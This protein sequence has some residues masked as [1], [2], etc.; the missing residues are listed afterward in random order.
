MSAPPT[1]R[2]QAGGKG[3][4]SHS[5]PVLCPE[6]YGGDSTGHAHIPDNRS[7]G[8]KSTADQFGPQQTRHQPQ[9]NSDPGQG[10]PAVNDHVQMRRTD[11]PES[12][13]SF[14][15]QPIGHV[16]LDRG[17]QTGQRP[18]Q[19]PDHGR[20][21]AQKHRSGTRAILLDSLLEI[22]RSHAS[23]RRRQWRR[24]APRPAVELDPY[25]SPPDLRSVFSSSGENMTREPSSAVPNN[26]RVIE[27]MKTNRPASDR[28]NDAISNITLVFM[29]NTP[30]WN[31][32][33]SYLSHRTVGLAS[34]GRHRALDAN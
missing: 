3:N 5:N 9:G 12:K 23:Q 24:A 28:T 15:H 2:R 11:A 13:P 17:N 1:N 16:H 10:T 31:C 21:Q 18:E 26:P 4:S 29:R 6:Q 14:A 27:A 19:Q 22:I 8:C 20:S 25:G 7:G 33:P 34:G 30:S 32:R